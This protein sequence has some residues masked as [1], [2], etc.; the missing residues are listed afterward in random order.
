MVPP[1]SGGQND[2]DLGASGWASENER[3]NHIECSK[4]SRRL[5]NTTHFQIAC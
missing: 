3:G 1:L 4:L 5:R 2:R